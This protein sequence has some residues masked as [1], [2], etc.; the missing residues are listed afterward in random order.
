VDHWS[1]R[2]KSPRPIFD[3][4]GNVF[5][6]IAQCLVKEKLLTGGIF[7]VDDFST[8]SVITLTIISSAIS[9]KKLGPAHAE[10]CFFPKMI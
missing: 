10:A 6:P 4:D 2:G 9:M 3:T 5:N 1:S 8:L 7:Y